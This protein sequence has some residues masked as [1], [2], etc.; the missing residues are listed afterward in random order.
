[1]LYIV[2]TPIG[3]LE[4]LSIRIAK[5]LISVDYVLAENTSSIGKLLPQCEKLLKEKKNQNQKIIP[6]AKEQE[7]SVLPK[8]VTTLKEEKNVALV[9]EAGM[10]LIS[11]PGGYLIKT[12]IKE[13]IKFTVIPGPS[14]YVI[15]SIASGIDTKNSMFVGFLPKKISEKTKLLINYKKISEII[16]DG[17][18]FIAYESPERLSDTLKLLNDNY[19]DCYISIA[20]EITK[21]H[22]EFLHGKPKEFL[23]KTW[24]GEITIAIKF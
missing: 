5:T 20:R 4:D 7:W 16:K 19:P 14:A 22:E 13:K 2:G 18:S 15:E 17:V 3:N 23:N 9:S 10:P 24:R 6:F 8:V 11:D 21:L 12:I 1:M